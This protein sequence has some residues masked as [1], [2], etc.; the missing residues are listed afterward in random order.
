MTHIN[1]RFKNDGDLGSSGEDGY[2]VQEIG[3]GEVMEQDLKQL[4]VNMQKR[5]IKVR[6]SSMVRLRPICDVV[7]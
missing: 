4:V 5:E 1:W 2:K 7:C 6:Q 3:E